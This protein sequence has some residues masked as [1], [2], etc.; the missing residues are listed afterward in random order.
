M[1][2]DARPISIERIVATLRTWAVRIVLEL[3]AHF[4][5]RIRRSLIG[6]F[7][8]PL[9]RLLVGRPPDA[10]VRACSKTL[11]LSRKESRKFLYRSLL[12][13]TLFQ[14]EW[15]ALGRRSKAGLIADARNLS[16]SDPSKISWLA[17]QGG[18]LIG[19]MHFGPYS[20]GL[21]W[22]IH[23]YLQGRDVLI[24]KT[25][26]NDPDEARAI[27]RLRELGSSVE[28]LSPFNPEDAYVLVKRL[29]QGAVALVLVDLPPAYGRSDTMEL[30][31]HEL[32]ITTGGADLAALAGVPFMLF[33][34]RT[35]IHRDLL[36]IGD[37]F[38]VARRDEQ[39][40][41]RAVR[42]VTR[43]IA[44]SIRE[45]PDH[46]HMWTRLHEYAPPVE[47]EKAA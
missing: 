20:L 38:H 36:E 24:L 1:P 45:Q 44:A 4:P 39:S 25:P 27:A 46:W 3:L 9:I 14:L 28:F 41:A 6:L 37:I 17:G 34:V 31:G 40:R 42:R 16:A 8:R 2:S 43:F 11:A 33:R 32:D 19:T 15:L 23:T 5:F 13:D 12:L 26:T 22:L 18:A 47:Q 30:L 29:R 7:F 21:V 35:E 10:L